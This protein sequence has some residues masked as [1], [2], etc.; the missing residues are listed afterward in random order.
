MVGAR[1]LPTL[2][3]CFHWKLWITIEIALALSSGFCFGQVNYWKTLSRSAEFCTSIQDSRP[4]DLGSGTLSK[5][6]TTEARRKKAGQESFTNGREC[7]LCPD[8]RCFLKFACIRVDS[9]QSCLSPCLRVSV[10]RFP[11]LYRYQNLPAA[12]IFGRT[13]PIDCPVN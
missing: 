4:E 3:R 13:W 1:A 12:S 8:F 6:S 11:K 7:Y 5:K 2:K 10:V 9:Q